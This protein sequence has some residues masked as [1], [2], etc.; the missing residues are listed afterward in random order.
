MFHKTFNLWSY[1]S[2]EFIRAELVLYVSLEGLNEHS[3]TMR[4]HY[5]LSIA[6]VFAFLFLLL[7]QQ[8]SSV[9]FCSIT[10]NHDIG[11]DNFTIHFHNKFSRGIL[12][13]GA[14]KCLFKWTSFNATSIKLTEN[15]QFRNS[16]WRNGSLALVDM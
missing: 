5:F 14:L 8:I 7:L 10:A 1:K 2:S 13:M 11:N 9:C 3:I 15:V 12:K 4:S 16:N 6:F